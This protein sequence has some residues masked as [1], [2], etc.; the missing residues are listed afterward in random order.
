MIVLPN[1]PSITEKTSA[2]E[3]QSYLEKA[4]SVKYPII[5]EQDAKGKCIYIGKT[6]FAKSADAIVYL[7][8]AGLPFTEDDKGY[9]K[10]HFAG[11]HM[12]NLF[13]VH[14]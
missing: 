2:E 10:E 13:F 14:M 3:V 12:Q 11:K 9:V 6:E 1:D 7:I 4:L 5:P 8:H